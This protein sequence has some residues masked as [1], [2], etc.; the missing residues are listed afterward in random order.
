LVRVIKRT[1]S[2]DTYLLKYEEKQILD[3]PFITRKK[4]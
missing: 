4:T 3:A 2:L 1:I